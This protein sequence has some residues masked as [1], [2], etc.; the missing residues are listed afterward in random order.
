MERQRPPETSGSV[1]KEKDERDRQ[2]E[3]RYRLFCNG[4]VQPWE[5]KP[6][7]RSILQHV[8]Y[9]WEELLAEYMQ[10]VHTSHYDHAFDSDTLHRW[11]VERFGDRAYPSA[12]GVLLFHVKEKVF[13][14]SY[15]NLRKPSEPKRPKE[16]TDEQRKDRMLVALDKTAEQMTMPP[17]ADLAIKR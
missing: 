14:P 12:H 7:C 2:L 11:E 8:F 15:K 10:W 6:C 5:D 9:H 13:G 1:Y 4:D 16:L 17:R 3:S